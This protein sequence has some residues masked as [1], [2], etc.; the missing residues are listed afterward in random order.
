MKKH[1]KLGTAARKLVATY[2][3]QSVVI[4]NNQ[5]QLAHSVSIEN[6]ILST[7]LNRKLAQR[8]LISELR[9]QPLPKPEDLVPKHTDASQVAER[10]SRLMLQG[11]T[12][13]EGFLPVVYQQLSRENYIGMIQAAQDGKPDELVLRTLETQRMNCKW[14]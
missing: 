14:L 7:T 11:D 13:R 10:C 2:A 5:L 1:I 6:H 8:T 12:V 4:E 9:N 3:H